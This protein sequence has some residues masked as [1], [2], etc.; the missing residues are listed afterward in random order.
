[1]NTGGK[2]TEGRKAS[3]SAMMTDSICKVCGDSECSEVKSGEVR[4]VECDVCQRWCHV[5]CVNL[6]DKDYEYLKKA[7]KA[8]KHIFWLCNEC[9]VS[10]LEVMKS[11]AE[12]KEK[13]EKL[14]KSI[15]EVKSENV[16]LA[17]DVEKFKA[18]VDKQFT[19]I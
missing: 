13:S 6:D 18:E 4:W 2:R 8:N 12:L 7:K 11:V 16:K 9:S 3:V 15:S 5:G 1:M 19:K 17:W 10:S 14:E